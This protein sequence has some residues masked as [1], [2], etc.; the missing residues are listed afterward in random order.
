MERIQI[1]SFVIS[2]EIGKVFSLTNKSAF[3][4]YTPLRHWYLLLSNFGISTT[5]YS[6]KM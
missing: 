5:Q 6:S 2:F 1:E 3:H 4:A